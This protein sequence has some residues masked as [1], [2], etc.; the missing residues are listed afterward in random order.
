MGVT[1]I[2][3]GLAVRLHISAAVGAFLV[4]IALSGPLQERAHG[5]LRPLR[6]LFAASFFV[7][8]GRQVDPRN[9]P[10]VLLAALVL[11]LV[12]AATNRT[13]R[14]TVAPEDVK[15]ML[16]VCSVGFGWWWRAC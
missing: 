5:V 10:Q 1:L 3:A 8:F 7:L 11:A 14:P 13:S 4:G 12:T 9:I 15:S 2:V 16:P 6:D